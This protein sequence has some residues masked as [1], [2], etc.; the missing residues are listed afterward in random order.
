MKRVAVIGSGNVGANAAFFIAEKGFADVTLTDIL[1]GVSKGKALDIMEAAP[2]RAYRSRVRGADSQG[3]IEGCDVVVLAAGAVRKPATRREDLF[4][5]NAV[6]VK[7]AAADVARYAPG[8]SVVVVTE[9]VDLNTALFISESGMPRERVLGVGGILGSTRLRYAVARDLGLSVE[10]VQA[11]VFGRH[12]EEMLAPARFT[13][14]SGIPVLRLMNEERFQSLVR[15]VKGAGDFIVDM[16]KR[17][18]AYYAPSAAVAE[19]ADALCR[20]TRRVLS[21]STLFAGE[22]GIEG[23]A[24]SVPAVV[25]ERGIAKFLLPALN[26]DENEHLE[27]SAEEL[28]TLLLRRGV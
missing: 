19:L 7:E 13:S 14:V 8:C 12:G 11:L 16:A 2:I 22:Y 26:R 21:V 10:N 25:G 15:E 17:S 6:S 18:S 5:R 1:E 23:V 4:E 3:E 9:P 20:D 24:M 28:K 27:R